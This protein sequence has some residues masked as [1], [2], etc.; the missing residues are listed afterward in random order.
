MIGERVGNKDGER[1]GLDD[2]GGMDGISLA[3]VD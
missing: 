3:G 2:D 1:V